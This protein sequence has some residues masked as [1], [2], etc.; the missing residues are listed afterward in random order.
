MQRSK[1]KIESK[2][3]NDLSVQ[4]GKAI[5]RKELKNDTSAKEIRKFFN[6]FKRAIKFGSLS[7]QKL[8]DFLKKVI[9]VVNFS[10]SNQFSN[11]FFKIK[12]LDM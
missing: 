11:G 2:L 5:E 3:I 6:G 1:L 9:L 8:T 12:L 7:F 10:T 4:N